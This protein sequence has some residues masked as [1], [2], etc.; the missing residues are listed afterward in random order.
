MESKEFKGIISI[1]KNQVFLTQASPYGNVAKEHGEQEHQIGETDAFL[2]F[3]I[4]CYAEMTYSSDEEEQGL[5]T[6]YYL[7]HNH[8]VQINFIHGIN[9]WLDGEIQQTL[10]ESQQS[11]IENIIIKNIKLT[12]E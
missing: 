10:T 5:N 2:S 4:D 9:V 8:K 12:I 7:H 1:L 3:S 6:G 11:I